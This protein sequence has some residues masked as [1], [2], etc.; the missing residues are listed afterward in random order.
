MQSNFHACKSTGR[1]IFM[2]IV[3]ASCTGRD[4]DAVVERDV[5]FTGPGGEA[6]IK[7]EVAAA[8]DKIKRG[9]MGRTSLAE[10]R[11]MLFEL[12]REKRWSFWMHDTL[13]PLD[14]I[15]ISK[16]RRVV[17]VVPDAK[18][19]DESSHQVDGLSLYVLEVNAG[20]AAAHGIERGVEV[21]FGP[22]HRHEDR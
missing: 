12:P 22:R 3:T 10:H 5:T 17:G 2:L 18:P 8:P 9:L 7:A 13:I 4:S 11:G 1:V 15:F 19:G 21:R 16:H 6:T 14:M 20:W